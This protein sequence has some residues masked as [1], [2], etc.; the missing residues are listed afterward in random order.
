MMHS[1]FSDLKENDEILDEYKDLLVSVCTPTMSAGRTPC[2]CLF[3]AQGGVRS[4]DGVKLHCCPYE[5]C[6]KTYRKTSHLKVHLRSHSGEK[7]FK[8]QWGA[9]EREFSR[10]DELKR[11]MRTH[12]DDKRFLCAHCDK[13]FMRSDHL[14]KHQKIHTRDT[15]NAAGKPSQQ[16]KPQQTKPPPPSPSSKE[17]KP[18]PPSS[19]TTKS[20]PPSSKTNTSLLPSSKKNK[21]SPPSKNSTSPPPKKTKPLAPQPLM[22][23]EEIKEEPP[24]P[25]PEDYEESKEKFLLSHSLV[26]VAKLRLRQID[27]LMEKV[28]PCYS[29][30]ISKC[31]SMYNA[32][33]PEGSLEMS[34]VVSGWHLDACHMK[35]LLIHYPY[36]I[37]KKYF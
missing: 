25:P 29:N 16:V 10:S 33:V 8:C 26:P 31:N 27:D 35:Q 30:N 9:C 20:L 34:N 21:S 36:K 4:D 18:P 5:N 23:A 11:H 19:K 37:K 22:V 28:R 2:S 1:V 24:S 14:H 32:S 17:T 12:T 3:C 15:K 13:R 6:G 7:P